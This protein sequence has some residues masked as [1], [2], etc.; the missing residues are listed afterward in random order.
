MSPLKVKAIDRRKYKSVSFL[1]NRALAFSS[2]AVD[3]AE[4]KNT[5]KLTDIVGTNAAT[6]TCSVAFGRGHCVH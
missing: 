4:E 5:N 3:T 6:K 2:H 1:S